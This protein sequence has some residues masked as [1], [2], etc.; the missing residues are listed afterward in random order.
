M[1]ISADD[2]TQQTIQKTLSTS[3]MEDPSSGV[4]AEC[5]RCEASFSDRYL[6]VDHLG[7]HHD[8]NRGLLRLQTEPNATPRVKFQTEEQDRRDDFRQKRRSPSNR[9]ILAVRNAE[10]AGI[11]KRQR[12]AMSPQTS[13]LDPSQ[14]GPYVSG[15]QKNTAAAQSETANVEP[16]IPVA[17]SDIA[18]T[19]GGS[20]APMATGDSS[21]DTI[22]SLNTSLTHERMA[23]FRGAFEGNEELAE[24]LG[25]WTSSMEERIP[26]TVRSVGPSIN[27]KLRSGSAHFTQDE[28]LVALRQLEKDDVVELMASNDVNYVRLAVRQRRLR[29][30]E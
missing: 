9:D 22:G 2:A 25:S 5:S 24:W 20:V 23:E 17:A 6:M 16:A 10:R 8:I 28:L 4:G 15:M 14:T 19:E 21:N 12:A 29:V 7:A 13:M 11:E 26:R 18:V 27:N 3:R 1:S 30:R